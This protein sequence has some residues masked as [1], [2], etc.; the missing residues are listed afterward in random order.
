MDGPQPEQRGERRQPPAAPSGAERS[1]GLASA[2]LLIA[3]LVVGVGLGWAVDR[4]L[5]SA[6][7][8]TVVFASLC[9]LA[10]LWRVLKGSAP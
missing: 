7:W 1:R 3:A 4:Q 2:A 10:G 6:P 5:D 9:I 8:W